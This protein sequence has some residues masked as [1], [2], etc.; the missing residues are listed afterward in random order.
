MSLAIPAGGKP[1]IVFILTQCWHLSLFVS[2]HLQPAP[3]F[4][5]CCAH[6]GGLDLL[7]GLPGL[8]LATQVIGVPAGAGQPQFH[9]PCPLC[10][11]GGRDVLDTELSFYQSGLADDEMRP[12]LFSE[13]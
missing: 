3:G 13:A 11:A 2:R 1:L 5:G 4:L 7:C 9:F 10:D 12:C 6:G 8:L